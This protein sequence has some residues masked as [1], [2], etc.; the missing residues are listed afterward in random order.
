M[1]QFGKLKD[2]AKLMDEKLQHLRVHG[3][4]AGLVKVTLNGK[5]EL[6]DIVIDPR[7][8]DAR[9]VA[10]L[11]SLIKSAYADAF[12]KSKSAIATE[13]GKSDLGAFQS[14]LKN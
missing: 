5:L 3:E 10:M 2:E 14:L 12:A 8:V 13:I 6:I 9:E 4:A 1:S 11:Q 7:A